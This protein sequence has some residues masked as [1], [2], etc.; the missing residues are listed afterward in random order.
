MIR[1]DT[2]GGL[3]RIGVPWAGHDPDPGLLEAAVEHFVTAA[4]IAKVLEVT[5]DWVY[6]QAKLWERTNGLRGIP[7]YK[8]GGNRRFR[9]SEVEAAVVRA[10]ESISTERRPRETNGKHR[11]DQDR[12]R[13]NAL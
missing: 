2:P 1:K 6:E 11:Q 8:I 12:Q 3:S 4:W 13:R 5:A 10:R 7:S 9:W